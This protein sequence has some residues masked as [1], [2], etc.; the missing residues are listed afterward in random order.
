MALFT[1]DWAPGGHD[2]DFDFS[3]DFF[4]CN[5]EGPISSEQL[6]PDEKYAKV[7]PKLQ[8]RKL[9]INF[10]GLANLANNHIMDFGEKGLNQTV[11]RLNECGIAHVG[12]GSNLTESRTP[13]ELQIAGRRVVVVSC[14]ERQFGESRKNRSGFAAFGPWI[15]S[16]VRDLSQSGAIVVVSYHGGIEN[17]EVPSPELQETFRTLVD[18]GASLVWGHHAHVPQGW[19]YYKDGLIL[20]GLGN[21]ATDPKLISHNGMG[22]YSLAVEVDFGAL[23]NS[24]FFITEQRI[25]G[26]KISVSFTPYELSDLASHIDGCNEAILNLETLEAKWSEVI[27][28]N[29]KEFYSDILDIDKSIL[30]ALKNWMYCIISTVKNRGHAVSP[31]TRSRRLL[32]LHVFS[33][34]AHRISIRD[35]LSELDGK[36]SNE[37]D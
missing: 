31:F 1:G 4:F 21:F 11:A 3:S 27:N 17:A 20:F 23:A 7:G 19:E 16:A 35:Y 25:V 6:D 10:V 29:F 32:A 34:E 12:T 5:L 13:I 37:T 30:G 33:T 15:F 9:P 14:A 18:L 24:K 2:I 22:R 36:G 8:S 26:D 28:R